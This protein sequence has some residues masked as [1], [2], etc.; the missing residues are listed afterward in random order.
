MRGDWPHE[1]VRLL[2]NWSMWVSDSKVGAISPYPAYRLSPPGPRY[3]NVMPMLVGEAEDTDRVIALLEPRYQM[4]LRMHYRW[5][6][7]SDRSKAL[8][9]NCNVEA[10]L[11]RLDEAHV[12][13]SRAWHG[14][15]RVRH[16]TGPAHEHRPLARS[17]G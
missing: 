7:R 5:Q 3:G 17:P 8:A 15:K 14:R 6:A 4:P 1:I 2:E 11:A 13:F 12:L 10:Y 16:E 9:C